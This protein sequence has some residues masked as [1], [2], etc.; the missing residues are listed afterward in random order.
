MERVDSDGRRNEK[1]RMLLGNTLTEQLAEG[2]NDW[3]E[4][5]EAE[6]RIVFHLDNEI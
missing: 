5:G 2:E 3:G 1:A 6:N 4:M